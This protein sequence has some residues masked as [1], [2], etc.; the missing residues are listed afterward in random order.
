MNL[1]EG[2]TGSLATLLH[3]WACGIQWLKDLSDYC[4]LLNSVEGPVDHFENFIA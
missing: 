3:F 1:I 4:K 2:N